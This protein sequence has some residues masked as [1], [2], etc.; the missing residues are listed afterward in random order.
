MLALWAA[1]ELP[2]A[3][4]AEMEVNG[5]VNTGLLGRK[6]R[7]IG[8]VRPGRRRDMAV[9]NRYAHVYDLAG[10]VVRSGQL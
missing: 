4:R 2:R 10:T 1:I 5:Q 8:S 3:S 6:I 9:R 7:Q